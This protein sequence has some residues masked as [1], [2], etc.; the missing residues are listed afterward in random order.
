MEW[1]K[2]LLVWSLIVYLQSVWAVMYHVF[3]ICLKETGRW[4]FWV[5]R[6][7]VFNCCL[8]SV[9]LKSLFDLSAG[10]K[11]LSGLNLHAHT[12]SCSA[13]VNTHTT[14]TF[15]FPSSAFLSCPAVFPIIFS[16]SFL[17]LFT[18]LTFPL[19]CSVSFS[20]FC[21]SFLLLKFSSVLYLNCK[22]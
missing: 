10:Y 6:C 2:I 21:T 5:D 3:E 11:V 14:H 22:C 20:F 17:H 12:H 8:G 19:P 13:C 9:L 1:D 15:I 4:W 16:I 7:A 18:S